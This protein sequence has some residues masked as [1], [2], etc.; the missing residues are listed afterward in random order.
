MVSKIILLTIVA[1]CDG[2][3]INTPTE[4]GKLVNYHHDIGGTVYIIDEKTLL[5]KGFEYDGAG[6]DAFFLAGTSEKPMEGGTVLPYPY[7]GEAYEYDDKSI[8]ILKKS[9]GTQNIELTLP[10]G[11]EMKSI[12]WLSVWCRAFTMD[13]GSLIFP[14]DLNLPEG[15]KQGSK[16]E[17]LVEFQPDNT[18]PESEPEAESEPE[19]TYPETEPNIETEQFADP[20]SDEGD[21]EVEHEPYTYPEG[22]PEGG[23]PEVE[24]E[25]EG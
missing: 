17:Q 16:V 23:D 13:F 20:R 12:R 21:P 9:D 25:P 18:Y 15:S 22:Y 4:V 2:F 11:V 5:I 7:E 6:P 1:F 8:P 24:G 3:T 14:E 19:D 10:S